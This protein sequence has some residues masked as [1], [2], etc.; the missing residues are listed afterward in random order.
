MVGKCKCEDL[1]FVSILVAM[2]LVEVGISVSQ[3]R[4]EKGKGD[5]KVVDASTGQITGA[6][7]GLK[8][9]LNYIGW[10]GGGGGHGY[11]LDD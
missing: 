11:C 3:Y 6:I 5:V 9:A 1:G 7:P 2:V 8:K 10:G 4:I